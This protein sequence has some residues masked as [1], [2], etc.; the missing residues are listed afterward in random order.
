[1]CIRYWYG[2]C[3]NAVSFFPHLH[4]CYTVPI[5]DGRK[6]QLNVPDELQKIP[7]LLP[8]YLVNI[9]EFTLALMAYTVSTYSPSSGACK[10]QVTANL[11]IHFGVVLHELLMESADELSCDDKKDTTNE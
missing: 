4:I 1:M 10:D 7:D 11:H 3:V 5:Y 8:R 6:H 9:P 2:Y